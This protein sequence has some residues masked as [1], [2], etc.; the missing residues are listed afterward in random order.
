MFVYELTKGVKNGWL[1][2]K[3]FAPVAARGYTGM[4][5][6]FVVSD[7]TGDVHVGGICKVAGLGGDPYS[8]GTYDYSYDAE[9]RVT[10]RKNRA[11][12]G[13][14][15]YEWDGAG[16]L[17]SAGTFFRAG[18]GEAGRRAGGVVRRCAE[19]VC[20]SSTASIRKTATGRMW[21]V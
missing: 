14:T 2:R 12:G 15:R 6:L 18:G 19:S 20:A 11:T 7:A 3:K 17:I 13:I 4:V 21:P 10:E 5:N 1:D 8:D 9:G 16:Q